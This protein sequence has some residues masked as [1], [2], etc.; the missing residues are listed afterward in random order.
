[1]FYPIVPFILPSK[2]ITGIDTVKYALVDQVKAFLPDGGPILLVTDEVI[3][4]TGLADT[5]IKYLTDAGFSVAVYTDVE[6]EP[7]VENLE[8]GVEYVKKNNFSLVIGLGGGS[9]MDVSKAMAVLPFNEGPILDYLGSHLIKKPGI[10]T[11]QLPTTSGTG[12]EI[13]I[14][15]VFKH[16]AMKLKKVLVSHYTMPA[17]AIVDPVLTLSVPPGATAASGVD[18]LTHAI[19]AYVAQKA[20]PQT[21]IYA[22]DA[23]KRISRHLRRAVARGDDINARYEMSLGSLF[24]GIAN[25]VAS[26]GAVH[27][28]SYPL[29]G[30]FN[31]PHG[32]S[33]ALMLPYVMEKIIVGNTKKFAEIAEFMG[34]NICGLPEYAAADKAIDAVKRLCKD[35]GIPAHLRDF[36]IPKE[37]IPVWA[38]LAIETQDRLLSNTPKKLTEKDIAEIYTAAW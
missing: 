12:S 25:G 13:T 38:K 5:V 27:A 22:A 32:V 23:I 7:S 3:K 18:A 34:E 15:S 19:E 33:N 29:G 21:D 14:N 31:L 30:E 28:L 17:V 2:V 10:P 36:N 24:G 26:V 1:M 11:F 9:V 8:K 4:K 35:V 37:V 20:T 16:K 6:P